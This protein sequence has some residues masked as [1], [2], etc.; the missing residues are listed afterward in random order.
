MLYLPTTGDLTSS[1]HNDT[2]T[3]Y[4]SITDTWSDIAGSGSTTQNGPLVNLNGKIYIVAGISSTTTFDRTLSNDI[5][6]YKPTEN[7]WVIVGSSINKYYHH[8]AVAIP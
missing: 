3:K 4:D 8:I 6:V 5:K 2:C 1:V 7:K